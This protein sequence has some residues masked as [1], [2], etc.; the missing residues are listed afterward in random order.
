MSSNNRVSRELLVQL[1]GKH[2]D[3]PVFEMRYMDLDF[4]WK[5]ARQKAKLEHVRFKDLRSQFAIYGQKAGVPGIVTSKAMGHA[6][7]AMTQRYQQYAAVM[8]SDQ[9]IALE[10]EMF[11]RTG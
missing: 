2:P 10:R 1:K 8:T 4:Y 6:S 7:Q 11:G 5:E 3:Q 9:A